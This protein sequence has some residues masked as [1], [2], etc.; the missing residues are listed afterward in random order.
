VVG[1]GAEPGGLVEKVFGEVECVQQAAWLC[2]GADP[3]DEA[4]PVGV[5][6]DLDD[7]RVEVHTFAE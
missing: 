4:S 6:D 7:R 3:D 2:C 5:F 1:P